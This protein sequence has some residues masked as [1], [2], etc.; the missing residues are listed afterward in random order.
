MSVRICIGF[1]LLALGAALSGC[2]G[3]MHLA[4]EDAPEVPAPAMQQ[5]STGWEGDALIARNHVAADALIAN[6]AVRLPKDAR[7]LCATFVDR[8]N[9]DSASSFGRLVGSQFV[10]RL[11]Q[12]GFGVM[13]VRLRN[14]LGIRVR[15][16]EFALSRKTAQYMRET[17]DAHAILVGSYTVDERV[18]FVSSLVA[19][20]DT[21]VVL[22]AHEYA[23]ANKGV[24]ARLLDDGTGEEVDFAAYLRRR[25][26]D[27]ADGMASDGLD[28]GFGEGLGSDLFTAPQPAPGGVPLT[29]FDLAPQ[30]ESG[31]PTRLFPPTRVQ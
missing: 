27:G 28:A 6:L 15:E 16:G 21:G 14:E 22:A 24:V 31:G 11:A 23:V 10:S 18:V 3:A 12:A 5:L 7:I 8:D 17:Y 26:T 20:L 30:T 9:F 19:R 1:A 29:E 4:A 25:G 2:S 13:E